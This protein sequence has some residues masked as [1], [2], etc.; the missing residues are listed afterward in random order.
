MIIADI[1]LFFATMQ[2]LAGIGIT[3]PDQVTL[4]C[5]D[6]DPNFEWCRPQ[7]THA[8]WDNRPVINRVVNWANNVS[9]GKD[10]HRKSRSEARLVIGG[11][12]GPLPRKR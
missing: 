10:D 5:T 11:T 8:A 12:I 1:A 2:Y 9:R 7:I 4:A 3:A 6:S